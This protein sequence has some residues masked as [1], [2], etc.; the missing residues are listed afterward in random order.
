MFLG[1][2]YNVEIWNLKTMKIV[3]RRKHCDDIL[4]KKMGKGNIFITGGEAQN[5]LKFWKI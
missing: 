5:I 2:K 3:C 4:I 1:E